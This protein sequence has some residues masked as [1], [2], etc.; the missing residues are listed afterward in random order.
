MSGSNDIIV[1]PATLTGGAIAIIRLSGEG[2]IGLCDAI[3][4]GVK[5]SLSD[6]PTHTL[7]YGE[8]VDRARV[9]DDVLVSVFRAPHSYTG[10]ESVEISCHGSQYIVQ[11]IISL[12][13]A[14][15]ARAADAG[16]FTTRAYLAGRMDLSQAEAVADMIASTSRA[17]H[18][19]AA[20]Q[21]RG[22][23]SSR[24]AE[25][26]GQLVELA[27]L[28]ELELDFSEEEVEF[29][30]R[31]RLES[32]VESLII[33]IEQLANSFS[34]GNAIKRG[35]PVAI[36]GEPNVGKSTLLNRLLG[37][38]RAMVSEIAG[39]TRDLIEEEMVLDGV[40]FRFIDTAGVHST[41]DKLELMGIERTLSAIERAQIVIH[42]SDAQ[43][44]ISNECDLHRVNSQEGGQNLVNSISECSDSVE[45]R[46]N[47]SVE[48]DG[49]ESTTL[50]IRCLNLRSDQKLIKVINK[51][52]TISECEKSPN[53]IYISAKEGVGIEALTNSLRAQV[54]T[55]SLFEGAP[56]VSNLRHYN[57][58]CTSLTALRT[59]KSGLNNALPTDLLCQEIREV[60]HNIG[61]ITGSITTDEILGEI[62]SKFCIGK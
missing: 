28:L 46:T 57:L 53:T 47:I 17:Q 42:L 55:K 61:S 52:D 62:F 56:I 9:V 29:A 19:M 34:V 12:L 41:D 8:I 48:E 33:E 38:E 16:E 59:A 44:V 1:A 2:S 13:L 10:E 31:V 54:E 23:Y 43:Y 4:R 20:T 50:D 18:A 40:T 14:Q 5:G 32:L 36:V 7:R 58:L 22:G 30:D 45:A 37:D 26:R 27:A 60:L 49:G 35:V 21:M 24:L 39:T 6:A 11:E 3:F 25:L 51:I 15:G